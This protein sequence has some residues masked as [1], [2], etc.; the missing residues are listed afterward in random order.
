MAILFSRLLIAFTTSGEPDWH[1]YIYAVLFVFTN[2][3]QSMINGYQSQRMSVLGQYFYIF[4][5]DSLD[6]L[7]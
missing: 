1:G 4:Y 7:C 6:Y 2:F 3:F 5:F